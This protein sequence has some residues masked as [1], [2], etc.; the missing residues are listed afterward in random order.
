MVKLAHIFDADTQLLLNI[1]EV[2]DYF[3]PTFKIDTELRQIH[4]LAQVREEVGVKLRLSRAE[5]LN[6]SCRAL[7]DLFSYFRKRRAEAKRLGRCNGHRSDQEAIA[8]RVY[9]NRMGNGNIE[10]GDGWR[11]RGR[12]VFQLTGTNNYRR[13][14]HVLYSR[15]GI[16]LDLYED[17]SLLLTPAVAILSA[18]AFWYDNKLWEIA[19]QGASDITIN[20]ITRKINRYTHSY[21]DRVSHFR[22]IQAAL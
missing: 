5:N 9:A 4:F 20:A 13:M 12:G 18:M 10:S 17:P 15:I 11:T 6:Y 1:E 3:A 22:A 16:K 8:N 21:K 19:D 7:S 2:I 14:S